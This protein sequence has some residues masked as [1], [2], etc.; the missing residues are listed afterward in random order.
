MKITKLLTGTALAVFLTAGAAQA[1]DLLYSNPP[2]HQ[3]GIT[4]NVGPYVALRGGATFPNDVDANFGTSANGVTGSFDSAGW[5][6]DVAFGYAFG[7]W[8]FLSPRL[9]AELDY[10]SA[11]LASGQRFNAAGPV[12]TPFALDG[13]RTALTGF[14][15]VLFDLNSG[16]MGFT[17]FL[18]A[19]VGVADVAIQANA[20][21]FN[22][23]D[24]SDTTFAWKLIAGLSYDIAP[25]VK[26]E[27]AYNY[28]TYSDV[29]VN[30][31]AGLNTHGDETESRVMGGLSY[32]F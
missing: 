3:K 29:T 24:D 11:Q 12:G 10:S 15:N 8:G 21:G 1:A 28:V 16:F 2:I 6:A 9:E 25:G 26:L 14:G 18:G 20:G 13:S 30:G 31:I 5:A 4:S 17:P 32:H 22:V 23:I 27:L 7:S 19:G